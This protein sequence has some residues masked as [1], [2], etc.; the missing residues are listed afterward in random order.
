MPKVADSDSTLILWGHFHPLVTGLTSSA[1]EN[2]SVDRIQLVADPGD[3]GSLLESDAMTREARV[4]SR[5]PG[6]SLSAVSGS[7]TGHRQVNL[8]DYLDRWLVLLFYPRDFSLI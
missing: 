8:D 1:Q 7:G 3:S 6:I 4:G 2:G 5:A